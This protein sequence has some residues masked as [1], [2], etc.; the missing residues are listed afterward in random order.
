MSNINEVIQDIYSS[1]EDLQSVASKK[2]E[3]AVAVRNN[4]QQD[5]FASPEQ[6][7]SPSNG[8]ITFSQPQLEKLARALDCTIANIEALLDEDQEEE[9]EQRYG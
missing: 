8:S 6:D 9:S 4:S 7:N 2:V 5:L 3:A 1:L